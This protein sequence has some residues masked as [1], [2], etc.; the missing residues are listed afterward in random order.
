MA[1]KEVLQRRYQNLLLGNNFSEDPLEVYWEEMYTLFYEYMQTNKRV[2]KD[3]EVYLNKPLG[4]W[5]A[6]Q[7]KL[8]R[9]DC[10]SEDQYQRISILT[11]K[12]PERNNQQ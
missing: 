5:L 10:L 2:P 1:K 9:Y 4:N 3:C 11:T 6:Y 12:E 7:I 8:M